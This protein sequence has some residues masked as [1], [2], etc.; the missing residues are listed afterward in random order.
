MFTLNQSSIQSPKTMRKI[1]NL[2]QYVTPGISDHLFERLPGISMSSRVTRLLILSYLQIEENSVIWDI[3][4][5]TGTIP[6]EIGLLCPQSQIIAIER[7]EEVAELL[8]LNCDKFG[9]NNVDI[10]TGIAPDCFSDINNVPDRVCIEG[11][12][13]YQAILP[14]VWNYLKSQGRI[15]ITTSNLEGLYKILNCLSELQ[16][17]NLEVMQSNTH[18][19]PLS[20]QNRVSNESEPIFI[21]SAE[22]IH[23]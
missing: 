12:N 2:W 6:I 9:V 11:G 20:A 23:V 14:Q 4:A 22:K 7:D 18:L 8:E 17:C 15:V 21:I 1:S 3:G 19:L 16:A 10:V 13:N 5:G